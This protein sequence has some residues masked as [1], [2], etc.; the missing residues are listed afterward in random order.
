MKIKSIKLIA[1]VVTAAMFLSACDEAQRKEIET[2]LFFWVN[3]VVSGIT[4][5]DVAY[6]RSIWDSKGYVLEITNATDKPL[7]NVT[8]SCDKWND[9][10]VAKQLNPHDSV[11][12]GWV[13]LPEPIWKGITYYIGANGYSKKMDV[14]IE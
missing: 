13:E 14:K 4:P 3:D 7:Y 9:R 6:R 8:V 11:E 2:K 5:V 12:V 1:I 10:I